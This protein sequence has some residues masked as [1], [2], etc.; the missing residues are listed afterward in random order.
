MLLYAIFGPGSRE[1]ATPGIEK[2]QRVRAS[3][4][5]VIDGDTIEWHGATYVLFGF[6]A[7]ETSQ[8]QCDE[9]RAMGDAAASVLRTVILSGHQVALTVLSGPDDQGRGVARLWVSGRDVGPRLIDE[10]LA[11]RHEGG[12][13]QPWCESL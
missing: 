5:T 13:P 3:D 7:P 9:E 10:G 2:A 11:R 4:L 8:A 1:A 6:D 12:A